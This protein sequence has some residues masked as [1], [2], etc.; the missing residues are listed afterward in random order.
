MAN[1]LFTGI[2][3][4]ALAGIVGIMIWSPSNPP[5]PA[6]TDS[7]G[8]SDLPVSGF[9]SL[10]EAYECMGADWDPKI[11][12]KIQAQFEAERS[13][14][15]QTKKPVHVSRILEIFQENGVVNK[16]A[17]YENSAAGQT[18]IKG[19]KDFDSKVQEIQDGYKNDVENGRLN[20]FMYGLN[21][22]GKDGRLNS[23]KLVAVFTILAKMAIISEANCQDA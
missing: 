11:G 6:S 10:G 7:I 2:M 16:F 15:M 19:I 21:D 1:A 5:N 20:Q 13:N 3:L 14:V 18:R 23:E 9:M 4:L 8:D 17:S 12:E 22:A